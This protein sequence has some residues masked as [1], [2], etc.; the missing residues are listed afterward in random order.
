[1]FELIYT[2]VGR[3]PLTDDEVADLLEEC[4]EFNLEHNVTGLLLYDGEQFMQLLEGYAA[5]VEAL[6]CRIAA[7]SRHHSINVCSRRDL[8][9]RNLET[10]AMAFRR[11]NQIYPDVLECKGEQRDPQTQV[12]AR[13]KFIYRYQQLIAEG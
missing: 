10:W 2:S 11:V 1:M 6:F 9:V 13:L 4:R 8:E 7:D 12:N 3:K 5:E